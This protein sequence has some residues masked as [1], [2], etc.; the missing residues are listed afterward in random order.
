MALHIH[1][2]FREVPSGIL[3]VSFV[4]LGT[5]YL[6]ALLMTFG[7]PVFAI[8]AYLQLVYFSVLVLSFL[9]AT[10]WGLAISASARGIPVSLWWYLGTACPMVL[11]WLTL[12]VVS[13]TIKIILLALGFFFTFMLDVSASTR[14]YAPPW[15]KNFRKL[16][17]TAVLIAM[18]LALV[19]IRSSVM[20]SGSG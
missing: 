4:G 12:V 8:N 17:T 10:N 11:G 16:M 19:A 5:I 1:H 2:S 7:A 3:V 9:G 6:F 13:P 18:L 15:Y 14:G 20:N